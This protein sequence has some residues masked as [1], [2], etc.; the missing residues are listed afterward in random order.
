VA[1]IKF[2]GITTLEDALAAIELGVDMLGFNFYTKSQRF[3]T[4]AACREILLAIDAAVE[5]LP[6]QVQMVGVFVN[7]PPEEVLAILHHC[8]LDMA[9]LSGDEPAEDLQRIGPAAF[10]AIRLGSGLPLE[11]A[12]HPYLQRRDE[13]AFLLDAN[14]PGEYGGTGQQA[15]WG[16]SRLAA[17]YFPLLLAGGLTPENAGTAV[18]Q[19][20]PWGVDVASGIESAP[21]R[22]DLGKME[23]FVRAVREA[24]G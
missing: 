1:K 21:G 23:A 13:P 24:V 5:R 22:K 6:R 3:I 18:R 9:Q 8:G 15:D 14:V 2:C 11:Q 7:Q 17:Q 19:V 16:Q 12:I 4:P 10:K 20:R